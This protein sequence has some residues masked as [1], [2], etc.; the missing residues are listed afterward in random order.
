MRRLVWFLSVAIMAT[1]LGRASAHADDGALAFT[2]G[3][4]NDGGSPTVIAGA[5][6]SSSGSGGSGDPNCEWRVAILDG[7][8]FN[9]NT[10]P[11]DA[12]TSYTGRWMQRWCNGQIVSGL[13]PER[14]IDPEAL[15]DAALSSIDIPAPTIR[16]SPSEGGRTFVQL[17]TWLWVDEGWWRERTATANAGPVTATVTAVPAATSWS[18]GDGSSLSC[19][20]PGVPW[21][22]G[23]SEGDTYCSYT[24]RRPSAPGTFQIT[25]TVTFEVRWT[26]NVGA[27]GSLDGVSR[28]A[29]RAVVVD[30]IQALETR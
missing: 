6:N 8:L 28:S 3:F 24:Y 9:L 23:M 29:S 15:A 5:A 11:G 30:E 7:D 17:P 14:V 1:V 21:R 20:G 4:V 22:R 18:T 10:P 13:V 27:S 12:V 26:S 16:T 19:P 2:G 25:V